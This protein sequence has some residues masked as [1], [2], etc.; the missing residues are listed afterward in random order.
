MKVI[1]LAAGQ[2]KRLLPRTLNQPKCALELDNRT[3]LHWQLQALAEAGATEAV[4]ST[5]FRA[6]RVQEIIQDFSGFPVRTEHNP[7]YAHCD[8]LGTCWIVRHEMDAPFIVLNGD[9]LFEPEVFRRLLAA[10]TEFPITVMVHRKTGYDDDDMKVIAE[11]RRLQRVDKRLP[12]DRVA[13]ESIGMIRFL[14][15]GPALFRQRLEALMTLETSL[16]R[17]YLSAVDDLARQGHVGIATTGDCDWCEIDD[18]DDLAHAAATVPG[19]FYPP[20]RLQEA[21]R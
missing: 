20:M 14:G 6:A 4:V 2:G 10:D 16:K 3:V 9:T 18:P 15:Q 11:G 5:G 8:N 12:L 19:W 21:S 17:W 7:F 13:G 1:I